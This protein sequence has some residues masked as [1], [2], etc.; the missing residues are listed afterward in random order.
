MTKLITPKQPFEKKPKQAEVIFEKSNAD[1]DAHK[2][3][4]KN[5]KDFDPYFESFKVKDNHMIV[6]VFKQ[7]ADEK[8][9]QGII[10][11]ND[12]EWY[13]TPGG[14]MKVRQSQN[15]YQT[16]AV[17]VTAGDLGESDFNKSL[18]P[19]TIVRLST[20]KLG[21]EFDTTPETKG[22]VNKGYFLIHAAT[23]IGIEL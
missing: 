18:V 10:L 19:G 4:N 14:Q 16:K 22:K 1:Y 3:Y 5:I 15:F 21:V 12:V 23:I 11:N 7:E 9:S 17:V 8:S 13:E 20:N 2:E 6:R